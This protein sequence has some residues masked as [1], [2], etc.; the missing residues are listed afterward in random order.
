MSQPNELQMQIYDRMSPDQMGRLTF[1]LSALC[2]ELQAVGVRARHPDYSEDD[3]RLAVI[4]IHLG[5][6]LFQRVYPRS[7]DIVP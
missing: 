3:V 2:K 7:A 6:E 1:E 5:D 4:R